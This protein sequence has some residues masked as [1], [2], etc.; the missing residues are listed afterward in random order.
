MASENL[1]M[2]EITDARRKALAESIQP[3]AVEDLK[4]L[5]E[6][7]FPYLDHPWHDK[8]FSFVDENSGATF[9]HAT[10]NDRLHIIYCREKERGMWFL[11]G[12]GMGPLQANGL[13]VMKEI[14]G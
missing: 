11:P 7:L 10:T 3:I 13:A 9:Y 6:G 4:K 1:N 8:F 12:S 5:G 14:A 2:D